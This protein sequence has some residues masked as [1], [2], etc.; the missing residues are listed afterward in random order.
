MIDPHFPLLEKLRLEIEKL[1]THLART[2]P[3]AAHTETRQPYQSYWA[4]LPADPTKTW[5]PSGLT[6]EEQGERLLQTLKAEAAQAEGPFRVCWRVLPRVDEVGYDIDNDNDNDNET[7]EEQLYARLCFERVEPEVL[8]EERPTHTHTSFGASWP[9]GAGRVP[10]PMPAETEEPLL[11]FFEYLHLPP[12][13][14]DVSQPFCVLAE[15]I[16]RTLPRNTERTVA[17]RKLLE[18]KDCAVRAAL[19]K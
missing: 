11:Q 13:L 18:A 8:S 10:N 5:E 19:M 1:G 15:T 7:A 4:G 17:L 12:H 16:V 3:A 14:Q 9:E 6:L 2:G